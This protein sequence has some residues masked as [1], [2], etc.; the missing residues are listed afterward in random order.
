MAKLTLAI[1]II[2]VIS[3]TVLSQTP[4]L[5]FSV[6]PTTVY[7]APGRAAQFQVIATS[8]AAYT[9]DDV[10]VSFTIPPGLS[11]TPQT[12]TIAKIAPFTKGKLAFSVTATADLPPGK[13]TITAAVLYTYCTATNCFQL[14]DSLTIPVRVTAELTGPVATTKSATLPPWALPTLGLVLLGVGIGLWT[15]GIKAP[16]YFVLLLFVIGGFV[17]GIKLRQPEQAQGIASVLCTSCVGIEAVQHAPPHLSDA[18]RAALKQITSNIDLVVFYAP[19][20]HTCPYA[21]AMVKDV[22]AINPHVKYT[23]VDV[24]V[25][26]A[27][28]AQ[29]GVIRNNRT[30][31]PAIMRADTGA[32]IFGIRDLEPRLLQLLGVGK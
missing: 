9:A 30:I 20:C 29:A 7:L 16:I 27:R 31:V 32:V 5:T 23:F 2:A 28:A 19:W 10:E 6:E 14:E 11:V 22:A 8:G 18:A 13:Y 25:D 15:R 3:V 4:V 17:Y 21:E 12:G 1:L 26:R 24:S